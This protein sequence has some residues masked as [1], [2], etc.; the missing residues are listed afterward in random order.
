MSWPLR[1]TSSL[2]L[3][4]GRRWNHNIEYFPVVV[5]A[6]PA[7]ARRALDV[8]CGDGI[9]CRRLAVAVPTVVG[10][11]R[12]PASID[13]ARQQGGG[14]GYAVG[15]LLAPPFEPESFD[16]VAAVTALHHVGTARG[17]AAM[18]DL[19]RPG[20]TLAAIGVARARYPAD[21]PRDLAAAAGTRAHQMAKRGR[22]RHLWATPAPTVWPPDEDFRQTRQEVERMLPGA[23][24]RRRLL[25]R[26]SV[27]WTKPA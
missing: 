19:V 23:V 26:W 10:L 17:L 3:A 15:D 12:D 5:G 14:P 4:D 22:G 21:L 24:F 8:G 20:G 27:T 16:L 1:E 25:W 6:L 13:A 18:R 7:G 2:A 9:L 11:D